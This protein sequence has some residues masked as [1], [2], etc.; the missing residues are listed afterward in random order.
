[1]YNLYKSHDLLNMSCDKKYTDGFINRHG[2]GLEEFS[3]GGKVFPFNIL[4]SF[5]QVNSLLM[6]TK[7]MKDFGH[8]P[9]YIAKWNQHQ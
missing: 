1:M 2:S 5:Q 6:L 9:I 3:F 4:F 8:S 7:K